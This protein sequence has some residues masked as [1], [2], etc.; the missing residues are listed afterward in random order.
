MKNRLLF[1]CLLASAFAVSV[2]GKPHDKHQALSK[3]SHTAKEKD[4]VPDEANEGEVLPTFMTFESSSQE[5]EDEDMSYEDNANVNLGPSNEEGVFEVSDSGER[6]TPVLLSDKALVDLLQGESEEEE[7]TQS[8]EEEGEEAEGDLEKEEEDEEVVEVEEE[9]DVE[10]EKEAEKVEAM[11]DEEESVEDE[12]TG[13]EEE[14]PVVGDRGVKQEAE[15]EETYSNTEPEIP[16]DLDYAGDSDNTQPLETELEEGKPLA[17]DAQLLLNKEEEAKVEEKEEQVSKEDEIPTA[18]DDYESQQDIQDT[19]TKNSVDLDG[20]RLAVEGGEEKEEK[21]LNESASHTLG[22]AR[23]QRKNQRVRKHPPQRDEAPPGEGVPDHQG[24]EGEKEHYRTTDNAV[25]KPKR[26]RAGKW[27]PL[28]GMN[29]VQIRA[30]VDLYPSARPSLAASLYKPQASAADPCENFRCKRGKTCK[31]NEEKKPMCVCQEPSACPQSVTDYDH[32]C[33]TNN[34]TYDTSCELFATKC[35]LEGSKRGHRLHLDYTGPCKFI[36][37]CMNGELVQ[38]PLRMRDWLKNVLLQLY[39]HDSMYPGF[40]TPKQRI[41]VRKIHESERRLHAG[42]HPIEL[43][44]QDFEK[45]YNMYIY[46]VHWQFA[47]MDQHPSD[48]FLSHSE[49]AP[50]RVPLVPMEHCTSR[51]FQECDADKDKQ[52]SFREWAH[53]FGIKDEDMDVNLLF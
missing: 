36:A 14:E 49:L 1:L 12:E 24:D 32:V 8:E 15:V 52:V 7:E 29:P 27:A 47:Q 2:K 26:R 25:Y 19:E 23:K 20:T 18:T 9:V 51:F 42:D 48:R 4:I 10:A 38:F 40:L 39:E 5:Q 11:A 6:S 31:L 28:V 30:T 13:E 21:N 22:K 37:P 34:V 53:C 43:L 35:N 17:E 16:E 45:N 33:G 46:P 41:R 44:A 3:S 50:L